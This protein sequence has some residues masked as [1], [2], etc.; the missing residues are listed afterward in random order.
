MKRKS[1]GRD[2]KFWKEWLKASGLERPKLIQQLPL[3]RNCISIKDNKIREETFAGMLNSYFED[4]EN[5]IYK[6]EGIEIK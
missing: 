5:V 4:L 6:K 1:E 3:L 2:T